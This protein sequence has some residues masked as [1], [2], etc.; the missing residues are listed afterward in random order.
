MTPTDQPTP[1]PAL[2]YRVEMFP[3]GTGLERATKVYPHGGGDLLTPDEAAVWEYV[4]AL[5]AECIRLGGELATALAANIGSVA[6]GLDA[7]DAPEDAG[8]F[9]APTETTAT[10]AA[11][12]AKDKR[13][14]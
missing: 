6:T 9:Q 13:K 8:Q 10:E 11:K 12:P 3:Y 14:R 5:E 7:L 1:P 4:K 2:P